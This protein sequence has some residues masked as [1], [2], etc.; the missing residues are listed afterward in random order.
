LVQDYY[1]RRGVRPQAYE[2]IPDAA[3][4]PAR[5]EE[6]RQKLLV[7]LELDSSACLIGAFGELTPRHRFKDLIWA[8]DI[9]HYVYP[10]IHLLIVGDGPQRAG[11]MRYA[12]CVEMA[13]RIHFLG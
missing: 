4:P 8:I 5:S 3:L 12:E 7:E 13:D 1:E 9:L 2:V 6:V 11:L 10:G